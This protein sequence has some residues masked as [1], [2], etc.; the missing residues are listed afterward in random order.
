MNR[1]LYKP[2]PEDLAPLRAEAMENKSVEQWR[3]AFLKGMRDMLRNNRRMYRAFGP[4]WWTL[5]AALIEFGASEF[6]ETVDAEWREKTRYDEEEEVKDGL[7]YGLTSVPKPLPVNKSR[8][9]S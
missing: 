4:Y 1:K 2:T 5:K 8:I 3:S 7:G 9:F 6:G